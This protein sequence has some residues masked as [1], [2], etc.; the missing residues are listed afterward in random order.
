MR[1]TT[2]LRYGEGHFR[3]Y[4]LKHDFFPVVHIAPAVSVV[5]DAERPL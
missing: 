1:E 3:L 2:Y 4:N 5:K